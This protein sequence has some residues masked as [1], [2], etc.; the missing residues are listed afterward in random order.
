MNDNPKIIFMGTPEFAVPA[1]RKIHEKYGIHTVVTVP[2]K[3]KGRGRKVQPSPVKA[4]ADELKIPVIQPESLKD[5]NFIQRL[6]DIS[7]DIIVVIAFRILPEEVFTKAK[8]A[9]FNIHGSLLPKYRGAA[10]INRAIMNGEKET[11][12]TSFVLQKKVD[13][14][15]ILLKKKIDIPEYCTAGELHDLLMPIAAELSIETIEMIKSGRFETLPQDDSE[16]S[17]APKLFRDDCKI[18]WGKQVDEILNF[19]HGTSPAP[20]SWT[21]FNG[22][23]LKIYE[24]RPSEKSL[25]PGEFE[26]SDDEFTAGCENGAIYL[27][28]IQLPG[29]KPV[30]TGDFI[31]GYRGIKAGYFE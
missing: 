1:L 24:A 5:E 13:T 6:E 2:D 3:S 12:L 14:G 4:A 17:P 19:I 30:N 18:N 25:K 16:A 21:T 9:A 23:M 15:N 28:K 7:P 20:C 29:K 31:R 22:E 11:G 10:P 27:K 8:I 26:I